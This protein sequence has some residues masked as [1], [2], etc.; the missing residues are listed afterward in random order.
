[1]KVLVIGGTGTIGKAVVEL[2]QKNHDVVK[3]GYR[4]GEYQ[5]DISSKESIQVLF[6]NVGKVDAVICTTGLANFG[7]FDELT[8]QDYEL[9]LNNKL[10][11]IEPW[12]SDIYL[13]AIV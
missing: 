10:N 13:E 9:G 3:V 12:T 5:A 11:W 1:M 7:K 6:D 2:P 8:D 4:D